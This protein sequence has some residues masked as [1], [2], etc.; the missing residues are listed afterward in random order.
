MII[1]LK[2][3]Q[4]QLPR[5]FAE[6]RCGELDDTADQEE[7]DEHKEILEEYE[8]DLERIDPDGERENQLREQ[9]YTR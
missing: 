8:S 1:K 4:E 2:E 3:Y 5:E 6:E 7:Q 9:G